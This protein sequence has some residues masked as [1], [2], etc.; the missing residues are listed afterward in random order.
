[1]G[2]K[3]DFGKVLQSQGMDVTL[4][5]VSLTTDDDTYGTASESY[6]ESTI[7]AVVQHAKID[8]VLKRF[9]NVEKVEKVAYLSGDVQISEKDY[10]VVN[11]EVF[12]IYKIDE[13]EFAGQTIFKK[14]WLRKK[15]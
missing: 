2:L 9:G 10:L 1:M 7:K 11:S 3:E 5:T 4:R 12:G 15:Q 8:E 14:V 13:F 6:T